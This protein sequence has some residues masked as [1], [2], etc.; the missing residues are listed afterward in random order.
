MGKRYDWY[1]TPQNTPRFKERRILFLTAMGILV[2]NLILVGILLSENVAW[3]LS[4]AFFFAFFA[5]IHCF[6]NRREMWTRGYVIFWIV[7][8][9]AVSPILFLWHKAYWWMIGYGIELLAFILLAVRMLKKRKS[10]PR[11]R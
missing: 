7:F 4:S 8:V 9:F 5:A 3:F 11:K 6:D 10:K 2:L 1:V